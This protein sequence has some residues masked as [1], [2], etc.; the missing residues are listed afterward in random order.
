MRFKHGILWSALLFAVLIFMTG[1][2]TPPQNL[3][4]ISGPEWHIQQG[5]G[6]W[7]PRAGAPQFGGDIVFATDDGKA[8]VQ[9]AKTPL[10]IVTAQVSPDHWLIRFPQ[11]NEFWYGRQPA[12]SRTIWLYLPD[13]L[14]GKPLPKPLHFENEPGGN[15]R[16]TN[17]KTGEILEG[18]LSS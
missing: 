9:F 6:L 15:W 5:Q 11:L 10:T 1:C 3:F 14:A 7:T 16:L 8:F 13:A 17:V 4:T 2:A 12:P 18:F